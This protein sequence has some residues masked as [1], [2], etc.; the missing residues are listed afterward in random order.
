MD[1]GTH[2]SGASRLQ[3]KL[4]QLMTIRTYT[5]YLH[6]QIAC[7]ALNENDVLCDL[8][9]EAQETDQDSV[10]SLVAG[11]IINQKQIQA[12]HTEA[13]KT[14]PIPLWPPGNQDLKRFSIVYQQLVQLPWGQKSDLAVRQP[15]WP[16][17]RD[18]SA[19]RSTSSSSQSGV[20]DSTKPGATKTTK[21]K[22]SG[23][24][25][26]ATTSKLS[27]VKLEPG[28]TT[29]SIIYGHEAA[30]LRQGG[31]KVPFNENLIEVA[32]KRANKLLPS[33][34]RHYYASVDGLKHKNPDEAPI[35]RNFGDD[36]LNPAIY[37][38]PNLQKWL[39]THCPEDPTLH[40]LLPSIHTLKFMPRVIALKYAAFLMKEFA[41]AAEAEQPDVYYFQ[42]VMGLTDPGDS[43]EL[44]GLARY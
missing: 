40:Y 41:A 32:L 29:E 9:E 10:Y 42:T 24:A 30:R 27:Q 11:A 28:R 23:S 36:M 5:A 14:T 20:R 26:Q 1:R 22:A 8:L 34:M 21:K 25:V 13:S 19:T 38:L 16:T 39:D 12:L 18:L 4:K 7:N 2:S 31:R 35:Q 44:Q 3:E 17:S 6:Y 43:L 15:S 37:A 33:S